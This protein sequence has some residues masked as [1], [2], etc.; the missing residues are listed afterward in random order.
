M[1]N[2][3][4]PKDKMSK[5]KMSKDKMSKDKMSNEKCYMYVKMYVTPVVATQPLR[6][7]G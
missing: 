5:D 7:T 1:S 4:M 6:R 3:K 2:D